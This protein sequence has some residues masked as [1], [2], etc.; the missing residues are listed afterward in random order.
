MV[1]LF[2]RLFLRNGKKI[3]LS[4]Q[5]SRAVC[6][7]LIVLLFLVELVTYNYSNQML[8]KKTEDALL[9]AMEQ[10]QYIMD[11]LINYIDEVLFSP[12]ND[13]LLYNSLTT[14]P[15]NQV[16]R[17][18][19]LSSYF[20][21]N[22]YIPLIRYF[23][24]FNYHIYLDPHLSA[25]ELYPTWNSDP[26]IHR[27][28]TVADSEWF[29]KTQAANGAL[30]WYRDKKKPD[31]IYVARE[32]RGFFTP[33]AT[34][35]VGVIQLELNV[36]N[37]FSRINQTTLTPN[38][39][40]YYSDNGKQIYGISAS[41]PGLELSD[42]F[43]LPQGEELVEVSVQ[44][45]GY[46]AGSF[47][48]P[49]GW[50]L[51]CFIPISDIISANNRL[52]FL[53]LGIAAAGIGIS[54]FLSIYIARKVSRPITDLATVMQ[55]TVDTDTLQIQIS[56]TS[57]TE[58]IFYL[59]TS[60]QSLINRINE[61]L[62]EVYIHGIAVK[63]AEIKALQAQINPHF[64]YNTLDSISWAVMD[65]GDFEIPSIITS[66]SNILRYSLKDFDKPATISE[67]L[68]IVRLY[69]NIQHFCYS[70]EIHLITDLV[71]M[72]PDLYQMPK[73]T[74]QPLVE[75][76]IIH[77]MMDYGIKEDHIIIRSF[78]K[79]DG[80][81]LQV[82]SSGKADIEKM[83]AIIRDPNE[84][85]K[86]GI[87]N[88]HR[89][90]VMRYGEASGLKFSNSDSGGLIVELFLPQQRPEKKTEEA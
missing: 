79:E 51:L 61:L 86:H 24:S 76:A 78:P 27:Q 16:N 46:M 56:T 7:T 22:I 6:C 84:T 17:Q 4:T 44:Q 68:E 10:N 50:A 23:S 83:Y 11:T 69:V 80:M 41:A 85:Q 54:I 70:L 66:L 26:H 28:D 82:E 87:K 38:S 34:T 20:I 1:N 55:N 47:A 63:E 14:T 39:Y 36:Q 18:Q 74:L 15:D 31:S 45:K 30:Y 37:F 75:N 58:E 49:N 32:I 13:K 2:K 35:D 12:C 21:N 59:Y 62:N 42:T 48:L 57:E 53:F 89:R 43:H 65:T 9:V 88:I 5:I 25:C 52:L 81:I 29:Q 40:C 33:F 77:G 67:E 90:L 3:A 64:L 71:S 19:E 8:M 73:L 72:D 60:F